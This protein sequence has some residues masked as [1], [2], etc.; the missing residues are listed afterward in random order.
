[1]VYNLG[2]CGLN[3][4]CQADFVY[5]FILY[6]HLMIVIFTTLILSSTGSDSGGNGAVEEI[7]PVGDD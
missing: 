2:F 1:M 3:V 6:A 4:Y 7:L 5:L